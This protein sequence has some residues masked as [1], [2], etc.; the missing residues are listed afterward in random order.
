MHLLR[1]HV[2]RDLR[3][4]LLTPR[5]RTDDAHGICGGES[6]TEVNAVTVAFAIILLIFFFHPSGAEASQPA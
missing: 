3:C 6:D 2:L 4:L 1:E 5:F